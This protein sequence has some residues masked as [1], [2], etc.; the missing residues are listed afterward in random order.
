V[1]RMGRGAALAVVSLATALSVGGC[2]GGDDET[3]TTAQRSVAQVI[4][5]RG[6]EHADR[7]LE[8]L[9]LRQNPKSALAPGAWLFAAG[10]SDD[11]SGDPAASARAAADKSLADQGGIRVD[12]ADLVPYADWVG[13]LADTRFYLVLAP[14]DSIPRPDGS[15]TVD[16]RWFE[17]QRALDMHRA[18]ALQLEYPIIKQLESL[19]GFATAADALETARSREVKPVQLRV[20]GQ[21]DKRR[22]VLPD[23][24]P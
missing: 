1:R 23:E 18:G 10:G 24:A 2:F 6:G 12:A 14:A 20:V 21:G 3:T 16:A 8:T 22:A 19:A 11:G 7:G 13:P 15:Q 9:L 4:V 17:P 5:L